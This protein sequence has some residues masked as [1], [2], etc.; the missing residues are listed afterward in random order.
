MDDEG[1]TRRRGAVINSRENTTRHGLRK[2]TT[3]YRTAD[4]ARRKAAVDLRLAGLTWAE[5][6][7]RLDFATPGGAHGAV[8]QALREAREE[9]RQSAEELIQQTILRYDS[10]QAAHWEKALAGNVASS[11]IILQCLAGRARI[12]G[13]DVPRRIE[14]TG[15]RYEIVGVDPEQV[16]GSRS[17]VI[18]AAGIVADEE[19]DVDSVE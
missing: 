11:K 3:A 7:E 15:I 6:A 16:A 13:V 4:A 19:L 2:D 12:E 9:C 17:G 14:V 10:L 5:I 8:N 18:T 1:P